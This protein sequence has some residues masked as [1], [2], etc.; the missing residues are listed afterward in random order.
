MRR[1]F[2]WRSFYRHW[3]LKESVLKATGIGISED[4]AR[5]EFAID[6]EEEY[7]RGERSDLWYGFCERATIFVKSQKVSRNRLDTHTLRL[8]QRAAAS[9]RL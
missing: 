6:G 1:M 2:R 4:L 9:I 5:L 8:S 3:C 7:G